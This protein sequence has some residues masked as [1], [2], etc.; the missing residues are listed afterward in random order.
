MKIK[1]YI[2]EKDI[3]DSIFTK[4]WNNLNVQQYENGVISYGT[5]IL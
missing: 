1:M 3:L 4:I 5:F 2:L